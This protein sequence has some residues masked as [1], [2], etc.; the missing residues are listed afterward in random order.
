MSNFIYVPGLSEVVEK[1]VE[2]DKK[3]A[4]EAAKNERKLSKEK[5]SGARKKEVTV[6]DRG[7][8]RTKRVDDRSISV[9]V[10]EKY[11]LTIQ[12][13]SEYFGLT[14]TKLRRF[15]MDHRDEMFVLKGGARLLVKR[16]MFEEYLNENKVL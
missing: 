3:K 4:E 6:N 12:E 11:A 2:E 5:I 8:V 15:V 16:K 14:E 10:W 13:A 7:V 1:E 9:P